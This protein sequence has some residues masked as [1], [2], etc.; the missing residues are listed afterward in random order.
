VTSTFDWRSI[1]RFAPSGDARAEPL[2]LHDKL[3]RFY[4]VGYVIAVF[5]PFELL[6][7]LPGSAESILVP[8][9][10]AIVLV[11][12]PRHILRRAPVSLVL[13]T[14]VM[15]MG[16]SV[17][18][19]G[20]P[21]VSMMVL[22][23]ELPALLA[24]ALVVG[25]MQPAVV[26]RLLLVTFAACCIWSLVGVVLL[27]PLGIPGADAAAVAGGWGATFGHKNTLGMFAVLTVA[28]VLAMVARSPRRNLLL[29]GLV[30]VVLLSRSATAASGLVAVGAAHAWM[31]TIGRIRR[32][33]DRV[34]AKLVLG[35][36]MI[37]SVLLIIGLLPDLLGLYGKDLTF[38]GRTEI[39]SATLEA[40]DRRP[41]Q[42]YGIGGVWL[43][44]RSPLTNEL[45]TTIGFP[46]AHAHNGLLNVWIETGLVGLVLFLTFVV[47]ILQL[48][49]SCLATPRTAPYGRWAITTIVG[50]ALMSVSEPLFR[51]PTLA[52]LAIMWTVLAGVVNRRR[53]DE[54]PD[55]V[56]MPV[57]RAQAAADD[58]ALAL[59]AE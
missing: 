44:G 4:V 16:A 24:I 26:V 55:G 25:T 28:L 20:V 7:P 42:G 35:A 13:L 22:R 31:T 14:L 1:A 46:A 41:L 50:M 48:A 2:P 54:G 9:G 21:S 36:A 6:F 37:L 51:G 49:V 8:V 15:W 52:L 19:S 32:S 3:A 40:I 29:A 53:R 47:R 30:G 56:P 38:T 39:W 5:R 10:A 57:T 59:T 12:T 23:N 17:A 11:L 33:R 58:R 18:T 34:V 27:P 45:W 43:D